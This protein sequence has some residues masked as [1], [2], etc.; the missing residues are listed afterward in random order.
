MNNDLD[1]YLRGPEPLA[2]DSYTTL[3][4]QALAEVLTL[5]SEV[6][7][8]LEAQIQSEYDATSERAQKQYDEDKAGVE[9]DLHRRS[10]QI[11]EEYDA[12]VEDIQA[13][14][15]G[16]LNEIKADAR[17]RRKKVKQSAV[18]L[19]QKTEK[20]HQEQVMVTEFVA[21]G[22]VTKHKQKQAEARSTSSSA[23]RHLDALR[24]QAE[25]L[26]QLYRQPRAGGS[27]ASAPTDAEDQDAPDTYGVCQALVEERL[28][29]LRR[30]GTAQL[31]IGVRPVL[32]GA[33]F[34][35]VVL[36]LVGVL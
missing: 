7:R 36:M 16:Q 3:Q 31:F 21:E 23:R 20:E 18:D 25:S 17:H 2:D 15:E 30:L 29:A 10:T 34:V 27:A 5:S 1:A 28:E 4:R 33:A 8:P 35:V 9:Q 32:L 19:E 12:R 22:A 11:R 6:V 26:L 13:E 24:E 14:Y